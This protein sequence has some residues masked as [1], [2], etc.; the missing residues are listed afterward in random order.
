MTHSTAS[1]TTLAVSHKIKI[2]FLK[3]CWKSFSKV[4]FLFHKDTLIYCPESLDIECSHLAQERNK[5][6]PIVSTVKT[7]LIQGGADKCIAQ[8]QGF[9]CYRGWKEARRATHTIWTTP[10]RELSSSFFFFFLQGKA[11][12]EIYAILTEGLLCCMPLSKTGWPSLNMVIFPPVMRLVLDDTKQ[13][14]PHRL[15]IKFTS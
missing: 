8:L 15:L 6:W 2:S 11:M 13:W 9:S 12:K 7:N 3:N 14:P 4:K 10:R 5:R 1:C